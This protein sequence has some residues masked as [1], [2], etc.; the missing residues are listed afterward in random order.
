[1]SQA[2][3]KKR[4]GLIGARGFVGQEL[5][6]LLAGD[7]TCEVAFVVSKGAAGQTLAGHTLVDLSPEDVATAGVDGLVLG[8]QNGQSGPW[9][10]AIPAG[11]VVVDL[12]ADWRF[13]CHPGSWTYGLVEKN[14]AALQG[15]KRIANPGCYSTAAQ[16]AL[17]P[18][19]DI[20]ERAHVFGVSGYSGAGSSPS[21]KNDTA[22]L[23]DNLMPYD[24]IGHTQEK[25]M[26]A[27]A[28]VDVRFLPHVAP[29]FRGITCTIA[30]DL[31]TELSQQDAH[32]RLRAR[33]E[34][35]PLVHVLAEEPLVKDA[36]GKHGVQIGG[37]RVEGTRLVVVATIDNLL[38]GAATQALQNL[39]LGLGLPELSGIPSVVR[40]T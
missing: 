26:R 29:F 25:E 12:S 37:L 34:G 30:V 38:K 27:H 16:L 13:E 15:C 5:L 35:E 39:H 31:R 20:M 18:F 28:D 4:I 32:A 36:V 11:V 6:T 17:L 9:V 3:A 19:H 8:L 24:L 23:H 33:Y 10:K 21:R 2:P 40:Q 22:L 1:M 14:R 7:E